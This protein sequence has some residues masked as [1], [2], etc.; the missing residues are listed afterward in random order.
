LRRPDGTEVVHGSIYTGASIAPQTLPTTGTYTLVVDPRGTGSGSFDLTVRSRGLVARP[1]VPDGPAVEAEVVRSGGVGKLTF[2][3][4]QGQRMSIGASQTT[5]SRGTIALLAPDGTRLGEDPLVAGA[6]SFV[7][8]VTLPATGTYAVLVSGEGS[9]TGK[10]AVR[11]YD[12]STD[13]FGTLAEGGSAVQVTISKPGQNAVLAFGA[14]AGFVHRLSLTSSSLGSGRLVVRNAEGTEVASTKLVAGSKALDTAALVAGNYTLLVDPAR[15]VVG[16]ATLALEAAPAG[17]PSQIAPSG[18]P[19]SAG[20]QNA[21]DDA[22]IVFVGAPGDRVSLVVSEYTG[23]AGTAQILKPDGQELASWPMNGGDAFIDTRTLPAAGSY[24]VRIGDRSAGAGRATFALYAV[25]EVDPLPITADGPAVVATVG[26]PGDNPTLSFDATADTTVSLTASD[27]SISFAS[28]RLLGPAGTTVASSW[29]GDEGGFLDAVELEVTGSYRIVVDASGPATGSASLRLHAVPTPP[30]TPIVYSGMGPGAGPED[31]E[32]DDAITSLDAD[33]WPDRNPVAI[34]TPGE[35]AVFSFDGVAGQRVSAFATDSTFPLSSLRL[36]RP[37]G[38]ALASA[39]V[40]LGKGFLDALV[41]PE[42][43]SYRLIFDPSGPATGTAGVTLFSVPADISDR[44]LLDQPVSLDLTTPGQDAELP[45]DA[46]AGQPLAVHVT[47]RGIPWGSIRLEKVD[48]TDLASTWLSDDPSER[49]VEVTADTTSTYR[50]VIDAADA[51]T[52]SAE[53]WVTD[54]SA[55]REPSPD[56][57]PPGDELDPIAEPAPDEGE[58]CAGP[59]P[60]DPCFE[61]IIHE[62]ED[63]NGERELASA[64][65]AV[66]QCRR[67]VIASLLRGELRGRWGW[68]GQY[69]WVVEV[70]EVR[71]RVLVG[72]AAL[73]VEHRVV[74]SRTSPKVIGRAKVLGATGAAIGLYTVGISAVCS[75]DLTNPGAC[76]SSVPSLSLPGFV[77]ANSNV[78][79][80]AGTVYLPSLPASANPRNFKLGLG[81]HAT[82][83][84]PPPLAG[85]RPFRSARI[86]CEVMTGLNTPNTGPSC[87]FPGFTPTIKFKR[88]DPKVRLVA[89]HMHDAIH[90]L[91]KPSTLRRNTSLTEANRR[92]AR[93]RASDDWTPKLPGYTCDEY[94]F[95]STEQ[96]GFGASRR[97]VPGKQN[98]S[99]GGKLQA[100]WVNNHVLDHASGRPG[101][102]F[103]VVVK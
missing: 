87:V 80:S 18:P 61:T 28:V 37:D 9:A 35:N 82:G 64:A 60:A 20:W 100:F 67:V 22:G 79:Y 30:A 17:T 46:T 53:V 47:S 10:T 77:F 19:V 90:Q 98:S 89:D 86:R 94:P 38:D 49:V 16:S 44:L 59:D 7:E 71:T 74:L 103:K 85:V 52:G 96:G 41:L 29:L 32:D 11:V 12:T 93:C 34:G 48:G 102:T 31:V 78:W 3:G 68:T 33:D 14:D 81:V 95:A 99:Q 24:T 51:G 1:I 88:S 54:P 63:P 73:V 6:A 55:I 15:D 23:S 97:G 39:H 70:R 58:A 75:P 62:M 83:T 45:F 66:S 91:H 25:P 26:V 56:D 92:D 72:A 36:V 65:P 2:D 13:V 40:G 84:V 43:G 101:D 27:S 42:S 4:I 76:P 21:Q 5:I 69:C 8:P 57:P 50:L